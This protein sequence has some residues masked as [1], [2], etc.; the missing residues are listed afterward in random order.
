VW[1][2]VYLF[3]VYEM[4][5]RNL[6]QVLG[7]APGVDHEKLKAKFRALA[8]RTHPDVN[9]DS[10]GTAER[11]KEFNSAYEILGD[12]ARRATYDLALGQERSRR[13][14]RFRQAAATMLA[15]FIA[16]IAVGS[17]AFIVLQR[18]LALRLEVTGPAP[19]ANSEIVSKSPDLLLLDNDEPAFG[20]QANSI[21]IPAPAES[22]DT[23]SA[24]A[25][26][27]M[28]PVELPKVADLAASDIH[29]TAELLP[30]AD[31]GAQIPL[32]EPPKAA[33]LPVLPQSPPDNKAATWTTYRNTRL[34]F[35]L[36]VPDDIFLRAEAVADAAEN[37]WVSRDGRSVL[38][39]T[40]APNTAGTKAAQHRRLLMQQRYG[41]ATLDYAPEKANWFVLS[42][43]LGEEMFYERVTLS[44]DGRSMHSWQLI[45]P[46][47]E[48]AVYDRVV[49]E[50]H[51]SYRHGAR[52]GD[53]R[54]ETAQSSKTE[55]SWRDIFPF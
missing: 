30:G 51:R 31:P 12:P 14:R 4:A 16:T 54:R 23:G 34:G 32:A 41:G 45:Y 33:S 36:K 38:H 25:N 3:E 18:P 46:V 50:M 53:D 37:M 10:Q 47:S 2:V 44:C 7:L 11:F 17:T 39:I 43:T 48:R 22:P 19:V 40:S 13:R 24:D 28:V 8:K 1:L 55:P 21:E 26:A 6:Y 20:Y 49:E 52:C 42:G 35:S 29:H 9:A 27:A 5:P 15:S